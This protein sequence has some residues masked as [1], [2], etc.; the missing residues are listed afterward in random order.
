MKAGPKAFFPK[1]PSAS[2]Y[3][4]GL[5]MGEHCELMV[6]EF[7]VGRKEQDELA[8]RSHERAGKARQHL[9][10][11][12]ISLEG[13]DKDVFIRDKPNMEKMAS[14]KPVFDKE[15][16]TL[17]A[18]NSSPFTDGAAAIFTVSPALEDKVKPDAYLLDYEF[19]GVHPD[20][21]LLMGPSKALLNL[22]ERNNFTWKDFDYIEIHE[23]FAGEVLCNIL[24]L[25]DRGYCSR[26]FNSSYDPGQ[27]DPETINPWGSSIPYG[28]PFGAT[29]ARMLSQAVRYLQVNNGKRGVIAICAAGALAGAAIVEI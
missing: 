2:E 13:L 20:L 19:V 26:N 4:T 15:K 14:L 28:H 8:F 5:T 6:Q 1:P 12:L 24:A 17:T 3:S 25:N 9:A 10:D 16:G 21:G 29:G 22:L 27:L 23:A 7:K 11:Q 18:A